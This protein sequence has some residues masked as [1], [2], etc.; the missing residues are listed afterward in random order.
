MGKKIHMLVIVVVITAL[1]IACGE[2]NGANQT[3]PNIIFIMAD[4]MG[5]GDPGCYNPQSKIP[6][7]NID[8]LAAE[9]LRFTNA[10]APGSWCT[11]TRY[12]LLTGTYPIRTDLAKHRIG[13]QIEPDQ[14]TI[15][16]LLQKNGY[17]TACIGKWHLGFDNIDKIDYSQPITGGP[18]D[19]GFNEFFGMH[20][21]LDIPPY[22]YIENNGVVAA[23][24]KDIDASFTD[25]VTPIQGAFWR[26]GK[27]AP[28]FVHEEVQSVFTN[29]ALEF[30]ENHQNGQPF[31]LYL[32]LAAPHTP[33]LPLEKFK[34]SSLAG[35]YGDFVNQVDH[36]IGLIM[37]K[38]QKL[39]LD[40]STLVIFTSD[41]GPVWYP[42]D[43]ER[44]GHE[45]VGIL[46]GMK[47]DALDGAHRMPFIAH[48]PGKIKSGTTTDLAICF[49]DMLATFAA[50][51]GDSLSHKNSGDSHNI[52]PL[53]LGQTDSFLT[54]PE[55]IIMNR[56]VIDEDWKFIV[57]SGYGGLSVRYSE[58]LKKVKEEG[59]KGVEL[60]NI[61]NDPGETTNLATQHPEIVKGLSGLL[62][63]Y[64]QQ[65]GSK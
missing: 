12:G 2:K 65:R 51:V 11:P 39:D 50:I 26:A 60:Y 8:R 21:S 6:T 13:S 20:A 15:A 24:T 30:I 44:Y 37:Q 61:K 14:I 1:F 16:S 40:K 10:H 29:K 31:F 28:G 23:P 47:G 25:G 41:N 27:I 53:M 49:T 46:R 34:N 45:S 42:V 22:Y 62:E 63:K 59:D 32:P 64:K 52:L 56:I 58:E 33:W 36:S 7:P 38:L 54:R 35:M 18:L 17:H 5:Y 55:M 9:G 4:D 57:G 19:R 48:W 3:K 43:E